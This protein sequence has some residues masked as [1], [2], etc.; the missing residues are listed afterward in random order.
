MH[1]GARSVELGDDVPPPDNFDDF[2]DDIQL[3]TPEEQYETLLR[4]VSG[5]VEKHTTGELR[6]LHDYL[7]YTLSP[8]D[9]RRTLLEIIEGKIALR[10]IAK[11]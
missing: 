5:A 4:Y 9:H 3:M 2:L 11:E 1:F 7:A 8:D 10:G 6:M